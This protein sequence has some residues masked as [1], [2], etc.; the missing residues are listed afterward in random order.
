MARDRLAEDLS[1]GTEAGFFARER[2][3][4]GARELLDAVVLGGARRIRDRASCTSEPQGWGTDVA[5]R[6]EAELRYEV[7]GT[8]LAGGQP[9]R[10]CAG[11]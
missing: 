2:N 10:A 8:M 4:P 3:G 1:H 11:W 5:Q 7:R 9:S 6:R